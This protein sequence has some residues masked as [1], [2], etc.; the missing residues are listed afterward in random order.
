MYLL[1][2]DESG[3]EKGAEDRHF[4]LAGVAAFERQTYF[5]EQALDQI[6]AN[7]RYGCSGAFQ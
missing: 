4:V 5:L 3:N 2:L 1:Y 6:Q 7:S